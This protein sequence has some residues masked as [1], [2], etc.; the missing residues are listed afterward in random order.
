MIYNISKFIENKHTNKVPEVL[1][2]HK[3]LKSTQR[4]TKVQGNP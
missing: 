1:K 2:E 3:V 4:Y